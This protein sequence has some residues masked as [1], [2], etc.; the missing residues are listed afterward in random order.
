M[1]DCCTYSC[2]QGRGC[3]VRSN[4]VRRHP[5][6]LAEA[7]PNTPEYACALERTRPIDW[8]DKVVMWGCLATTVIV[9]LLAV[10]T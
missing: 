6:T 8:E 3:P 9:I 4:T 7:F 5:R 10:L 2:N 1:T